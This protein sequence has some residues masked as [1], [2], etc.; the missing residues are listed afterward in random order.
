MVLFITSLILSAENSIDSFPLISFS[1]T[2]TFCDCLNFVIVAAILSDMDL[3][4]N[5][6]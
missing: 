1:S 2:E 4:F 6:I 3:M 5:L